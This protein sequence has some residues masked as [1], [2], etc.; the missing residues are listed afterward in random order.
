MSRGACSL[1][2][3]VHAIDTSKERR[4]AAAG[5]PDQRRD[6]VFLDRERIIEERLLGTI[7]EIEILDVDLCPRMF[8]R[9]VGTPVNIQ[10]N[11]R[12]HGFLH[13]FYP[14]PNRPVI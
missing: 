6:L 5:R 2:R 10:D 8:G 7:K 3:I 4:F 11:P 14:Y 12:L 9:I 1:N 13:L